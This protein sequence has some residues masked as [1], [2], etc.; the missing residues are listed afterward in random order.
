MPSGSIVL[1]ITAIAGA[2]GDGEPADALSAGATWPGTR[3]R[4][5]AREWVPFPTLSRYG[6]CG[7]VVSGRAILTCRWFEPAEPYIFRLARSAGPKA[8]VGPAHR[9]GTARRQTLVCRAA[10]T[11]PSSSAPGIGQTADNGL[12]GGLLQLSLIH[13]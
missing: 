5:A 4:A 8:G 12:P 13:I 7:R 10:R 9:P 2:A 1:L 11:R 3:R 6:P